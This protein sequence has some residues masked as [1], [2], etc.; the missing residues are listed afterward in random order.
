MIQ[1]PFKNIGKFQNID[2]I[3]LRYQ[4]LVRFKLVSFRCMG[5][6]DSPAQLKWPERIL[7]TKQL[8]ATIMTKCVP[9]GTHFVIKMFVWNLE[10]YDVKCNFST[11]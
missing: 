8:N 6:H 5:Y 2:A 3:K 1:N 10:V 7:N 9:L 11:D 4:I